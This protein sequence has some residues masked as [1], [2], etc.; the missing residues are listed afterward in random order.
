MDGDESKAD[1]SFLKISVKR[2]IP[3][4]TA[5]DELKRV[6][7]RPKLNR[8]DYYRGTKALVTKEH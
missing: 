2:G 8:T 3:F 7:F 6:A 4:D 1:A 5:Y